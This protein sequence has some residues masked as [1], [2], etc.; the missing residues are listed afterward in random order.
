MVNYG[1]SRSLLSRSVAAAVATLASTTGVLAQDV[2]EVPELEEVVVTGS[3]IVRDPNAIASQPV[4]SVSSEDIAISG[5]F[6]IT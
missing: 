2:D 1:K 4:Q 3:R 6:S 5:E